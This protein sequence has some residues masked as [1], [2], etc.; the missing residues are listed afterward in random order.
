MNF[1]KKSMPKKNQP[2]LKA[3]PL[4]SILGVLQR[5]HP[6]EAAAAAATPTPT[7]TQH[8]KEQQKSTKKEK[9][10]RKF[11]ENNSNFNLNTEIKYQSLLPQEIPV[12]EQ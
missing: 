12:R 7:P 8:S 2:A 10:Q 11:K 4:T 5:I 9:I 1:E 6:E 3:R